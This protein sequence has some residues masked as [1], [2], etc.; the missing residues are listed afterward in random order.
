MSCQSAPVSKWSVRPCS[1]PL[2]I[3]HIQ[4]PERHPHL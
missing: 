3:R 2:S 1:R 4:C